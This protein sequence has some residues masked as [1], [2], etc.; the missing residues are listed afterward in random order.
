ML[1]VGGVNE[2]NTKDFLAAGVVG[3]GVGGNLVNK[4]WINS[5]DYQKICDAAKKY[6]AS[7]NSL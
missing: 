5:G 3:V 7:I 1:A 6:V 4:D 2:K